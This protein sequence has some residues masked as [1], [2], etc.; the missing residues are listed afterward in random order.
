MPS[1]LP[2][3]KKAESRP[4]LE[5]TEKKS[6]ISDWP[7]EQLVAE[8]QRL[9]KRKK[10]GLVWEDKPENVVEQCKTELPVLKEI[11]NKAITKDD[12]GP[13]NILIEGDNYH[14][15]SVLNY[16]HKGKIDFI[17][18]D[19]PYNTGA[20]DWKYNND[21]VDAE[22]TFRHSKWI[23]FMHKRL[24]LAKGLLGP[25][26]VLCVTIDNYEVHNLRHILG[27]VFQGKDIVTTVIVHNFRGRA[28]NNFALSH[29]YA[30]WVLPKDVESITRKE[31]YAK[32][33]TMNLRRT[34][35]NSLRKDRP[36]M[37]YGILVDSKTKKIIGTTEP[38][39]EGVKLLVKKR[40]NIEE[41]WPID[42]SGVERRWYY[43]RDRVIQEA[44]QGLVTAKQQSN[45]LEI[46]FRF[47]GKKIRRK[48][49]WIG[50]EYDSS[51]NGTVL[52]TGIIGHNDFTF[53]KSIYAVKECI[54]SATSKK[55]AIILDFFAG[56]G[57]TGHAVLEINKQDGGNRQFILCTNNENNI[58]TDICYPRIEKLI[59]GY[60]NTRGEK[61]LGFGGNLKYFRTSFVDAEPNDKNKESLT[62]QATEML[63][64]RESAFES[65]KETATI[66]IFKN[67]KK[68]VAIVFDENSIPSLKKDISKIGGTWNAY[69]FSLGEDT[70]DEE[71]QDMKEKITVAP[72]PEAILHV[73]RRL[74]KP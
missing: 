55:D 53:P 32:S 51:A 63:C 13:V 68:H 17:Y 18:I 49:V 28:K 6:D 8:V 43:G 40:P 1:P 48:S 67:Q 56:S 41:V 70:F 57:T 46:Y 10:Y 47:E 71:F 59:K 69:I 21:Y 74:F 20:R 5:V 29:E 22:D 50:P 16:T 45:S 33:A 54:E 4:L 30:V 31:E 42:R 52:L 35:Q 39:K 65:V 7:K 58:A 60:K 12:N 73:Y 24:K 62:R 34:G 2:Y 11:K 37:F 66:K 3:I 38:L 26:G 27:E 61:V 64:V 72:I 9:R 25:L 19:P 44:A 15:L 14:A 36:S 23:S